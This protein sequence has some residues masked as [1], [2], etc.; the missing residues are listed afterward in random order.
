LVLLGL[1]FGILAYGSASIPQGAQTASVSIIWLILA[2]LFHTLGELSLSPLGLSY[3][4]KLVPA[5][6]IGM[7]FGIWYIAIGLGNKAA[8][9][10]GGMIDSIT[11]QYSMS[12]FFMIFT[13]VPIAAGIIV[14]LLTPVMN[15]LMHGVK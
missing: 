13:I 2:Y 12:Y 10:M 3:V 5:K 11:A 8:G 1:G 4:S 14:M 15:K 9:S 6:V 7:M